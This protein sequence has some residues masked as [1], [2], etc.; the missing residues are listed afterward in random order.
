M[1]RKGRDFLPEDVN[2]LEEI[3]YDPSRAW[4]LRRYDNQLRS[5]VISP[6]IEDG[7]KQIF[8]PLCKLERIKE[9]RGHRTFDF[10]SDEA[11]L[12]VEVTS[13]H[14]DE[15]LLGLNELRGK[16]LTKQDVLRKLSEAIG[17]VLDKDSSSFPSY[18]KGGAICYSPTF[19]MF[20]GFHGLLDCGLAEI[21][22]IFDD[23][24]D[25]L[26]FFHQPSSS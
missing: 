9:K 1:P 16:A 11:R 17:H 2:N 8:A 23:C 4:D 19:R 5:E 21:R 7:V 13:L 24:L 18:R 12:L 26:V 14:V 10:K 3:H 6:D 22:R 15:S 25:F 20:S